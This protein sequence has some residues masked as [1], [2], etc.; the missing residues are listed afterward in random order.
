MDTIT[1]MQRLASPTLDRVMLLI[2][3]L[4]SQE[5][6]TV[7][8]VLAYLAVDAA[9]GRRLGVAFLA[10]AYLNDLLK[11][12]FARPRPFEVD[13]D[14][15]RSAAARE[16]APGSSF[17][18][19]HAQS[20][21]IFWVMAASRF[22]RAWFWAVAVVLVGLVAVSRVYLGVHYPVDVLVGILVGLLVVLAAAL[23]R[24]LALA[25]GRTAVV[26][27][28]LAAPM[29]LHLLFKTENSHVYLAAMSA[30][31]VGPELVTHRASGRVVTRLAMGLLGVVM[32]AAAMLISS[33]VLPEE[34]KRAVLPSYLR[35]LAIGL[36]G[37]L[38]APLACRGLRLSG[39]PVVA[40][41]GAATSD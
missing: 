34:V 12:A 3:D 2:T 17:P 32:V 13:P 30:F 4:G 38:L 23:A 39:G 36:T 7:L 19:G 25:P 21:T 9:F 1:A 41:G 40:A 5:A 15:L 35:Y 20:A 8:L 31:I 22:G 18:S 10:G 28:G 29:A 16:T 37:T 6:Y 33:A 11:Q 26:V 24:R 14:L 27:A